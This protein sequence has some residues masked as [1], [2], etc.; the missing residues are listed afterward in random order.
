MSTRTRVR[1]LVAIS[2]AVTAFVGL[3]SGALARGSG[4]VP[5]PKV[6]KKV[7]NQYALEYTG[8]TAG[9]ADKDLPP[10][11]I[12][13]VNG[14][15]G[16][17]SFPDTTAGMKAAVKYVNRE[18]GGIQGH[19][20]RLAQCFIVTAE[21]GQ[22]CGTEMVNNEDVDVVLFGASILGNSEFYSVLNGTKPVLVAVGLTDADFLTNLASTFGAGIVGSAKGQMWVIAE[23]LEAEKVA[24]ILEDSGPGR[25]AFNVLVKP[26]LADFGITDVTGVFVPPT[27]AGPEV[28]QALLNAGAETADALAILSAPAICIAAFDAYR[29]LDLDIPVATPP[30]CAGRPMTAHLQDVGVEGVVPDGWYYVSGTNNTYVPV[31]DMGTKIYLNKM[32]KYGPED[33]DI[34][35][36]F[37]QAGF[38][39]VLTV[40]RFAN[41][42]GAENLTP[43]AFSEKITSFTG[44][45]MMTPGTIECPG[46][47]PFA[48]LCGTGVEIEQYKDGKWIPVRDSKKGNPLDVSTF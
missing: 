4:D 2:V 47:P 36:G 27:A 26:V 24:V 40:V 44:P 3:S 17:V 19:R 39:N 41:E 11:T 48:S 23:E 6:P 14:Q 45:M 8:G 31:A 33:A 18:L 30:T 13:V 42:I 25:N 43:E 38:A 5:G 46:E 28:Q 16:A 20:V 9:K 22:K 21:D 12:G 35:G 1:R 10:I 34:A 32:A 7:S 29:A 15:G 37:A